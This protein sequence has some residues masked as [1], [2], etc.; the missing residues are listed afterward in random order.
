MTAHAIQPL[1][2][3]GIQLHRIGSGPPVVMVHGLGLDRRAWDCLGTLSDRFELIAYDL[4]GHGETPVPPSPYG[5]EELSEQLGAVMRGACIPRAHVI[6]HDLGGLVAQ[7]LAASEPGMVDHLVLCNTTPCYNDDDRATWQQHAAMARQ[8][9]PASLLRTI[10][11][12]WFTPAF[13]A[14]D[15]PA[16]RLMRDCLSACP[17]EGFARACEALAA[18]DLID[19]ASEIYARTLVVVGEH[20]TL[21]Y[22]EAADWLAQ[23]IAGAKLAFVPHAA[24]GAVLEQ[25]NWMMQVL[26]S[27]L[28]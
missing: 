12:M 6:G 28:G 14:K 11:P 5:V 19:I 26:R 23:S 1:D 20:E 22:R 15:P 13:L 21:A 16:L 17:A 24:H 4:P 10:E 18:A 8:V 27:F 9:G 3:T 25:P 2:P 7:H